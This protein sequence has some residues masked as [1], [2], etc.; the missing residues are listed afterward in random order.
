MHGCLGYVVMVQELTLC[1]HRQFLHK[2]MTKQTE[3]MSWM[4]QV[5]TEWSA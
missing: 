1:G 5:K 4:S 3:K 2:I